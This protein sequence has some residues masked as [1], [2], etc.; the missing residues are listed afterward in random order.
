MYH[1]ITAHKFIDLAKIQAL[2]FFRTTVLFTLWKFSNLDS[3]GCL[4]ILIRKFW[5]YSWS[6]WMRKQLEFGELYRI[7][8]EIGEI[9][10]ELENQ[11]NT[12]NMLFCS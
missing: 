1:N 12:L 9:G 4:P 7:S 10:Y 11:I 8:V 5:L 6:I 2:L 3:H